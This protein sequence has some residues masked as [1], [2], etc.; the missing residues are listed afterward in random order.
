MTDVFRKI[1]TARATTTLTASW[2]LVG[3]ILETVV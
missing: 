2:N 1:E 3:A